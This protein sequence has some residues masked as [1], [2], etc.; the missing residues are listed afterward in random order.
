M[1]DVIEK[2]MF[3]ANGKNQNGYAV[4]G[5]GKLILKYALHAFLMI[6]FYVK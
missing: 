2:K 4:V 6:Q 1:H 5:R 3:P